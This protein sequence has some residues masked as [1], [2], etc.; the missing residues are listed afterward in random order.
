[1]STLAIFDLDETLLAG[2]SDYQW[3]LFLVEKGVLERGAYDARVREFY[4]LY[5]SGR[6]TAA[7]FLDFKMYPLADFTREQ[8]DAWH[9]E[10]LRRRIAPMVRP[11]AWA[12]LD[13]H[14]QDTRVIV[15]G[16]N[17]FVTAPIAALLRVPTLIATKLEVVN[18]RFTGRGCG[19]PCFR[20][21]KIVR[22]EEW[23]RSRNQQFSDF[24]ETW[25]YTDSINDL[26]L[27]SRVTHPIAVHPD[28]R[29]RAHALAA[30]WRIVAL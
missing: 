19:T 23:L 29:L 4:D 13:R 11:G 27:L 24:D 21:G 5:R 7:E 30:G 8:L 10:F 14:R 20:E 26:P 15:T 17:E 9:A 25:F 12:L 1:M 2:D 28:D 6:L 18:G 22:L 3:G 16:T